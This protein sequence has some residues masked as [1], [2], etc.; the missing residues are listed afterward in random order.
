MT[1]HNCLTDTLLCGQILG[2][3]PVSELRSQ[4]SSKLRFSWKSFAFLYSILH[5]IGPFLF[6]AFTTRLLFIGTSM[7]LSFAIGYVVYLGSFINVILY[8]QLA[9]QW[10]KLIRQWDA[11]DIKFRINNDEMR[12]LR[13][14]VNAVL[15][16]VITTALGNCN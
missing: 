5:M 3:M 13:R 4:D 14:N 16:V 2:L 8:Y 9:K 1:L 15:I 10:P 7:S 12:I 6:L 11:M